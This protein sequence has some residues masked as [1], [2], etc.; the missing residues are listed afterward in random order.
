MK[1]GESFSSG[2]DMTTMVQ[3]AVPPGPCT[4]GFT[5]VLTTTCDKNGEE[6]GAP[7]W[8][9]PVELEQSIAEARSARERKSGKCGCGHG[10]S[11]DVVAVFN[12]GKES[13]KEGLAMG[14]EIAKSNQPARPLVARIPTKE[15][16]DSLRKS[17]QNEMDAQ[18]EFVSQLHSVAVEASNSVEIK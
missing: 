3:I 6:Y 11:I 9:D 16:S 5:Q 12:A 13:F 17:L 8:A 7:S 10:T 18:S 4:P 15:E 2:K 14:L 1:I